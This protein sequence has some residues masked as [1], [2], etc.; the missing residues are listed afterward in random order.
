MSFLL[1]TLLSLS[2]PPP[3]I[4]SHLDGQ[5]YLVLP[6]RIQIDPTDD[7][8][9]FSHHLWRQ[10]V[11]GLQGCTVLHHL[12]WSRGARDDGRH[13]LVLETP[14]QRQLCPRDAQLIRDRLVIPST[15]C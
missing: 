9:N 6:R 8:I 12:L 2:P 3:P 1:V 7:V 13:I 4:W 10:L 15:A 11:Q 5:R 14:C